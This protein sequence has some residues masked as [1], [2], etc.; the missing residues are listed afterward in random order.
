MNANTILVIA[1]ILP[2]FA[3]STCT[4]AGSCKERFASFLEQGELIDQLLV[5]INNLK[6]QVAS[7]QAMNNTM[8][9][10][11]QQKKGKKSSRSE[12]K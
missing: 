11:I 1:S 8:S 12:C 3:V 7:L 6:N 5:E 2:A 4:G 9:D 10:Y